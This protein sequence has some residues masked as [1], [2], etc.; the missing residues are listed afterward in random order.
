MKSH[1][2]FC[3][4]TEVAAPSPQRPKQIGVFPHIAMHHRAICRDEFEAFDVIAG[5][6][7]STSKPPRSSAQHQ[8]RGAGVRNDARGKHQTRFL[9]GVVNRSQQ[10]SAVKFGAACLRIHSD[11]S[12]SREVDYD[13]AVAG[14]E[15]SKA[16]TSAPDSGNNSSRRSCPHCRFYIA[17]VCAACDEAR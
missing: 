13:T 1:F 7:E 2:E 14:A 9:R 16:M 15:T 11:L 10:T 3:D 17:Y 4:N 12:H 6:A 5:Q 8:S